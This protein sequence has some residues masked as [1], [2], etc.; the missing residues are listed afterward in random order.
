MPGDITGSLIYDPHSAEFSFREGPVFTNLLLAD[1]INRTPPKTQSALLESMEERQVS[2]E[3]TPRPLPSPFMVAA[4]QNPVEYE[5]H[6][7][8]ARGPARP[9]PAQGRAAPAA[10]RGRDH[11]G[12]PARVAASTPATWPPPACAPSPARPTSMPAWRQCG[13]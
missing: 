12:S 7:P 4:T 2:V 1:E 10:A 13:R 11:G 5:G 6:L 8:V 3:G 9:V